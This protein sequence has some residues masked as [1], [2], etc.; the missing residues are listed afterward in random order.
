MSFSVAKA[1]T[2]LALSTSGPLPDRD[3]IP[4]SA[5]RFARPYW[6][7]TQGSHGVLISMSALDSLPHGAVANLSVGDPNPLNSHSRKPET[8]SS[9]HAK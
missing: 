6:A 5:I 3:K 8:A 7:G 9:S 1:R 4:R 2:N